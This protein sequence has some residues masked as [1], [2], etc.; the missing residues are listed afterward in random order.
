MAEQGETAQVGDTVEV[1]GGPFK[2]RRGRVA[3]VD[4]DR[5]V[6]RVL[7]PLYGREAP[8]EIPFGQLRQ[9]LIDE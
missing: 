7:I 8:I 1:E 4:R 5:Q 3:A 6:V 9:V 2:G